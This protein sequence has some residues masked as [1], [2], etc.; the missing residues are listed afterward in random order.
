[1]K[2]FYDFF[3]RLKSITKGYGS[4]EYE[5]SGLKASKLVKLD[6]R[7]NGE[8]V[9]ALSV[10]VHKDRAY[11]RGKALCERLRKTINRQ[12]FDV[13]VQAAVGNRI[14]SVRRSKL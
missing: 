10:I 4:F 13:A 3:D 12:Q 8:I 9:D 14:I 5:V 7:L 2:L 11:I 6:I 1:M